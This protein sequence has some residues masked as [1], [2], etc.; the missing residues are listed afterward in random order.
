M[1]R[2]IPVDAPRDPHKVSIGS[3]PK[4]RSALAMFV[5]GILLGASTTGA[6]LWLG[7]QRGGSPSGPATA[8]VHLRNIQFDPSALNVEVG[9]TVTWVNDDPTVHTVTSDDPAGPLN[10]GDL[11]QGATYSHTFATSG[12]FP[13]HCIPHSTFDAA[14]GKYAGMTGKIVVGSGGGTG[15]VTPLD[16]PHA[17]YNAT[18]RPSSAATVRNIVLEVKE[19]NVAIAKGVPYA[20]WTFGGTLPG[21]VIRVRVGDA[22][23]FTLFNNG[24]MNHSIDF[25]A[26]QVPWNVYYQ[27]IAPGTNL[28]FDWTPKFPGVFMYHCGASPVLLHIGNG[29]YAVIIVDPKVDPRP[30]PAKEFVLVQSEL[31]PADSLGGDRVYHGDLAKMLGVKPKYVVFN[32]YADQYKA[33]HLVA[34]AGELIR[35]HVL[36]AGPTLTSAFHV[37]GALFDRVYVEGNP[38]NVLVGI[39][40][41]NLPPSGGASFDLVIPDP[42]LYPFVTH[43]FA[44]TGLGAVGVLEIVP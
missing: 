34:K 33:A 18:T 23:H 37:I 15:G 25:H 35:I 42:G 29:M 43:A 1:K 24:T 22:L 17:T 14:Q 19:L 40:T 39:Q 44:Y 20:A 3:E 28:S 16:V 38:D 5:V 32:G 7:L 27:P 4:P 8:V 26:A 30:V 2:T 31:Y 9:T 11:P 6:G 13:Y 41:L 36:N 21:P 10:S 12:T